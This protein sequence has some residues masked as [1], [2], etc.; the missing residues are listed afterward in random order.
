[1][2]EELLLESGL[3]QRE[4]QSIMIL[5]SN[6]RMK[7]SEL[8]KEL[9]TTRL[10]AYNSLSRLQEMGIVTVTADRPMLFSSLDVNQAIEHIIGMRK[11]QLS[12]LVEGYDEL[13]KNVTSKKVEQKS[14]SRGV[15]DP[16]FAVLKERTH[17]YSRLKKM[18]EDS[19]ERLILLLGQYGILHLCR[20]PDALEAVN[21]AALSGVVIQIITHLDS[22]TIRFFKELHD[23]IE[24]R[25][26][27]ELE[28][29]GFVRD[30]SEVI[31]YLNIEDNPVGR[32]K[33]DAALIIE[34]SAFAE[35]HLNLIDTIWENA[36]HFETAVARYTDNQINDPLK[37]T[38]GEGSFLKNITSALGIDDELPDEDTPF[39]PEAFFA[40]GNEV[41]EARN[42]LTEGKLSNLKVLGIDIGLMLRQIGNRVGQ[43]IA[44]SLRGIEHDIE[45]L[46]EMMDWWEHAGLGNLEYDVD[47]SFHVRVGLHHPPVD[48]PDAL[49]MWEM[50]DGIIEGALSNRFAKDSNIVIQRVD[51]SGAANDLWHYIIH[52]HNS[53][54]LELSD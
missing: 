25:H 13:S 4:V 17:I 34:S 8:A 47:P 52:R 38:I 51:G 37:L 2:W 9:N 10:D 3:N 28:S 29:L 1:M 54:P 35:S 7:A 39:D 36:V 33:D 41:N 53:E 45:F 49:P 46:D 14:N 50:D 43:E 5:G 32:G 6:P 26:S 31:Q 20:N 22:R 21:T 24:V 19:D 30:N 11:Q 18:A 12:Q 15:D 48:D 44:F 16:R 27:D 40:A 23:S 42:Q